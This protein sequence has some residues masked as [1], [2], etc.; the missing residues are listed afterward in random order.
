MKRYT[1]DKQHNLLLCVTAMDP[2][3]KNLDCLDDT[4]RDLAFALIKAKAT[5]LALS[6]PKAV[7]PVPEVKQE[8]KVMRM[9]H[10]TPAQVWR[11][12]IN[13]SMQ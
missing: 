5:D 7:F 12:Q 2:R 10:H 6:D 9:I 8:P 3:F 13:P 4:E 11:S 1:S